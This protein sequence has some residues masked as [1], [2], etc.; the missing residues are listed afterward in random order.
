MPGRM[1]TASSRAHSGIGDRHVNSPNAKLPLRTGTEQ[2]DTT[3][4]A[5]C[6]SCPNQQRVPVLVAR[7]VT[8]GAEEPAQ[9]Y[10]LEHVT[11][12]LGKK[13]VVEITPMVVKRY[14]GDRL[15]E[16]AGQKTSNDEVLLL[17]RL[18]GDQGDLIRAKLRREKSLKLKT[19]PSPGRAY[20]ADEKARMAG[21]RAARTPVALDRSR[22]QEDAHSGQIENGGRNR[23]RNPFERYRP[24]RAPDPCRVVHP[25][26]R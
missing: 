10:A 3:G 1:A 22:E 17:L 25:E 21:R 4:R 8:K 2:T 16:N 20:T 11:H 7:A 26:V 24:G 5:L 18:F 14:Q 19:P 23:A 6:R 15:A 12:H 13:L 9:E